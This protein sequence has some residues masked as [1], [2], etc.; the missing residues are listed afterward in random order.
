MASKDIELMAHLMRRAGFGATRQE[1][2]ER[3]AKGYEATVEELLDTSD[4]TYLSDDVIRRFHTEMHESR[5]GD[6]ASAY[7]MY[8]LV[9]ASNPLVE[10]TALFWHGILATGYSKLNQARSVLN[11]VDM[12]RRNGLG[13]LDDL[14][15]EISKDPAMIVW[16]D[17]NTNH[18]GAINENYGRELLELFSMGIGNYTEDDI[19]ECAR[20]FTGWTLGNESYMAVR[21]SK[22]SIWPY[23]R[24]A[25]HFEYR[26]D[27]HDDGEKSFLGETG[28]FNG[29]DI[30]HIIA[31]QPGTAQFVARHMYSFFVA[32]EVPVPQWS[33]TAS[34]DS[35]AIEE[36]SQA[37][38]DSDHDIRS[39]LRTLFNSDFFKESR[40]ARVKGPAELVAGTV[41]LSG[42]VSRPSMEVMEAARV[43][44]FMGQ[45]ILSPPTVEGW[46]EG[47]EWINSGSLIE[48][49][50][51]AAKLMSD[52]DKPGVRAIMDRL[53]AQDGGEFTPDELVDGCL[54]LMGPIASNESSRSGLVEYVARQG[55]LSLRDHQHGDESEK[56]VAD[57]LGLIASTREYQLG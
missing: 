35:A 16:L 50:N 44:G 20:A 32:D 17:N 7:W 54:D 21:A 24:I 40:F 53:A 13:R 2:E 4:V 14:L 5:L 26:A 48:R 51:F 38:V 41:R 36:L 55:D 37:Y 23:S 34:R 45:T 25:W 52:V 27:D 47:T 31:R 56:R 12:F 43:A 39:M 10:K 30:V 9:T 28:K 8:R 33:Y 57:L 6:S 3:V 18:N 29:E 15:I 46:H 11:Q 19:K 42:G 1:L 22:D 49:V